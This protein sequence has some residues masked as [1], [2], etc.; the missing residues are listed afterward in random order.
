MLQRFEFTKVCMGKNAKG[1]FSQ[2][3]DIFSIKMTYLN[4]LLYCPLDFQRHPKPFKRVIVF[5]LRM[6]L[7]VERTVEKTTRH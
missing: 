5:R 7:K 6:A 4:A 3:F 1:H 2:N